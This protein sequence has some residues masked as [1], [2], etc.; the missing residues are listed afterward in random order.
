MTQQSGFCSLINAATASI[1][2]DGT[3]SI[4]HHW[5]YT[6]GEWLRP[7]QAD[8]V[9]SVS[10]LS[11]GERS[12]WRDSEAQRACA[13]V[14]LFVAT[15]RAKFHEWSNGWDGPYNFNETVLGSH[16]GFTVEVKCGFRGRLKGCGISSGG[17][18]GERLRNRLRLQRS[19][20]RR[21]WRD[22]CARARRRPQPAGQRSARNQQRQRGSDGEKSRRTA[23]PT[24]PWRESPRLLLPWTPSESL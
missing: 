8:G 18:S 3:E 1:V 24:P 14:S 16:V 21:T 19:P 4:N 22:A 2:V 5:E 17:A 9:N 15:V 11:A 12:Q 13:L 10:G 6:F 7:L 20:Q 23:D